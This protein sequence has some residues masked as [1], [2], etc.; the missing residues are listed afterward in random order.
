MINDS[1]NTLTPLSFEQVDQGEDPKKAII[2]LH[3]LGADG[4]DFVPVIPMLNLHTP[5]RFIFPHAPQRPVTMNGG[6][7]MPSWYDILGMKGEANSERHIDEGQIRQSIDQINQIVQTL[8][9][10]G[11]QKSDIILCGFSQG[12]AVAYQAGL[13][14]TGFAGV[15]A[16]STYLTMPDLLDEGSKNTP[17]LIHHGSLDD[18]VVP[19]LGH[20]ARDHLN[21]HGWSVEFHEYPMAHQ[22]VPEQ[23]THL[24][25]WIEQCFKR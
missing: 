9:Q 19:L 25:L 17:I 1:H 14:Q 11:F 6:F 7:V 23:L 16:L 5:T 21:A 2:W 12:G 15:M 18:V 24:G 13:E 22:V 3:G 10:E 20:K 4:H 8:V